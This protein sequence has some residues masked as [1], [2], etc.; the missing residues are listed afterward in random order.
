[1]NCSPSRHFLGWDEPVTVK[2]RKWLLPEPVAGPVDL[3]GALIVVPTR[4]AGR[5]LREALALFCA[6]RGTALLS[7]RAVPPSVLLHPRA[8][9]P[10]EANPALVKAVW[11]DVLL[12]LDPARCAGLFPA[13]PPERDFAWAARAGEMLQQ[14]RA[15]LAEGGLRPADVIA[16]GEPALEEPERWQ[17]LVEVEGRYL[18]RLAE[19]RLEDPCLGA[20]ARAARPDPPEGIRRIVV[21]A[22]PDPSPLAVR[23]LEALSADLD[24]RVLVHA[25]EDMADHFDAWGRPVAGQWRDAMAAI[26]DPEANVRL[27]GSPLA[28][29]RLAA[30]EMAAADAALGPADVSIGVADPAVIPVMREV[31][32][33]YGLSVFDPSNRW[34][35]DHPLYRLLAAFARLATDGGSY[36]ALRVFLRHPDV[37]ECLRAARRIPPARLLAELDEFQNLHLPFRVDDMVRPLAQCGD[38]FGRLAAAVAFTREQLAAFAGRPLGT[39]VR[40]FLQTVYAAREITS[41]QPRDRAFR[42][43]AQSVGNIL[44]EF[45]TGPWAA[46]R[47]DA[48]QALGLF[49]RRLEE[50]R[51]PPEREP[52][53]LDLEGWLELAWNDAPWL[54]ITGMNEGLVPESRPADVFL[55]DTLRT[56]LGLR[57]DAAR[58]ARDA[59]L[60]RSFIEPRRRQ[61]RVCFI[62]GKTTAAGDPLKPSRLLFRCPDEELPAR[63]A[64]LFAPARDE[65]DRAH[66]RI[67]FRLNPSPPDA[68]ALERVRVTRLSA[69]QFRDYLACPFRF[70]L[71]H[72]LGMEPLDDE[73][74]GPDELDFGSLVHAVLE[75]MGQS[76]A[77][78]RCPDEERLGGRLAAEAERWLRARYGRA[79]SLPLT[80]ALEAARNRLAW[81]ARAQVRLVREGWD[82]VQTE[83]KCEIE[84]GGM[85]VVGK[86]DRL[87]RHRQTGAVR[88]VDYKTS[89][90]ASPP[91]AAHLGPAREDTPDYARTAVGGKAR[92]WTDLQLPLYRLMA[93]ADGEAGR[94]AQVAYFNLPKAAGE[95]GVAPWAE[96]DADL[97]DSARR[98]ALGVAE[99]IRNRVFWP[100]AARVAY[101]DFERLHAGAIEECFEAPALGARA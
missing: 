7:C 40:A 36:Q 95:T 82:V 59:Y 31:L 70:Y 65:E 18:Q 61:G 56:R 64:R 69:T 88:I 86:L 99:K 22:V 19:L 13:R 8:S 80:L 16:R 97:L 89:D 41:R 77:L 71:R 68:Q 85:R 47:A 20:L 49:L 44:A 57:D 73:K 78:W 51:Y 91:A 75:K 14:L 67:S 25:P 43:A 84:L 21:A 90:K 83:R 28:Q 17:N 48:T 100:P 39:A 4:H 24:V 27:A 23:A 32:D 101:D 11:A 30:R 54:I 79:L 53:A 38:R 37:L 63:V 72:V 46:L 98:C 33:Q 87:D 10:V 74:P 35:K 50:E 93:A 96:L 58:L 66:A 29:G 45:E 5:R 1:M 9:S 52:G 12:G 15:T 26:P 62:A 42:T 34:L 2:V 6:D 55:P 76:R 3:A 60:M 81:A 94:E 92:R